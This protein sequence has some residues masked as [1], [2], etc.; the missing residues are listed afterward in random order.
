MRH[1]PHQVAILALDSV[2]PFD[3]A[4][5]HQVFGFSRAA[6]PARYRVRVCSPRPGRVRA[7]EGII[8]ETRHGLRTLA[9]ADTIIVPGL[10][11][12]DRPIPRDVCSALRRAHARGARLASICTGAFVLAAAG[13][14]D[15]RRAT[16]HWQNAEA[17]AARYPLVRVD[18]GVLYVADGPVFTSAG[19]AAGLDLC[20]H[21]VQRDFGAQFA[22]SVARE[23][24]VAP[25]RS[26]GQAQFI[27][28]PLEP[29]DGGSLEATRIWALAHLGQPLTLTRLA[30]HARMNRRTFTRRF[31]SETGMSALQWVVYQRVLL[32]RRLLETTDLP[33]SRIAAR[34][35]F[36]SALSLRLHFRKLLA[37][38][39]LSYRRAFRAGGEA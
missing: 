18:P 1:T 30:A 9:A 38:S 11:E 7:A 24:V 14:L 2:V 8:L 35:G 34:A 6:A 31:R 4:I 28:T 27:D 3:L 25:H 37:V 21:L 22:N 10:T 39:P 32:A 20:L 13:L 19:L 36:G 33:V 16:T 23:L 5:P 29:G 17:L 12:L 15:G 26:G